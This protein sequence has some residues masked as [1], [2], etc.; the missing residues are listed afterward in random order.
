MNVNQDQVL[1]E[2]TTIRHREP[3]VW[4]AAID[5][6]KP[7]LRQKQGHCKQIK[8]A[9]DGARP[10]VS[11]REAQALE[12]LI[13]DYQEVFETKSCDYGRTEKVYHRID[14]GEVRS[15]RQSPSKQK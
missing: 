11:L 5:D 13:A 3:A 14:T 8:E 10:N 1:S 7:H 4:A 15:I 2:C 6:Q 12:Q 9:V